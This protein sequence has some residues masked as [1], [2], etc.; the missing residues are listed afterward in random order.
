[1]VYQEKLSGVMMQLAF[2]VY[3]RTESRAQLRSLHERATRVHAALIFPLLASLIVLAPLLIPWLLGPRWAPAVRPTQILAVAGM[4]AAILTGYPQVMLALGRPRA[5]L[6]FNV[7][8]L[9][10]YAAV[11]ALAAGHGLTVVAVAVAG[12]YLAIL[13]GVY[14][15]LLRRHLGISIRALLAELAPAL[16]GCVALVGVAAPLRALLA[17]VLPPLL[18]LALVGCAGLL[19]YVATLRAVSPAAWRDLALLL[20][21]VLPTPALSR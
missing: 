18:A 11:V 6:R 8:M 20:A 17:P 16:V 10:G 1:V 5:L 3:S 21:R 12:F 2:P 13:A 19:T 14:R 15:L 7:A 9:G 4:V